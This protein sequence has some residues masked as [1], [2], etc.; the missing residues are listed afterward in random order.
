MTGFY[1][2][3][4]TLLKGILK[5]FLNVRIVGK[6]NRPKK[7]DGPYII[8]ANHISAI[9]PVAIAISI[10]Y[11]QP[12]Y[13]GKQEIE[14]NKL[15]RWFFKNIGVVPVT[16]SGNDV[17]ALKTTIKLLNDGKSIG[18][19][20]Q[21][22]R[23]PGVDPRTTKAKIGLGMIQ[24]Y[25]GADILPIYIHSKGNAAKLFR[26]KTLI[27]GKPITAEEIGKMGRGTAEY[28]RISGLIFDRICSL[29]E[30]YE[31]SLEEKKNA[32][33]SKKNDR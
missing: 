26:R 7:G 1:K 4:H 29:G 23:Y 14:K 21:G 32:K 18:I 25:A 10:N 11:I 30:E 20:P 28:E 9:D 19:F 15:A 33:K 8:C 31:R 12:H 3:L 22:K 17:G 2:F 6:E 5:V 24:S 27:M 16:R 13:L